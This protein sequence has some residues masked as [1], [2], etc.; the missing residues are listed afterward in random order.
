V[1]R[2]QAC[3][4]VSKPGQPILKHVVYRLVDDAWGKQRSEVEREIPVCRAC[5]HDLDLGVPLADVIQAKAPKVTPVY[6][7]AVNRA[8]A[9]A[10]ATQRRSV[11]TTP[12]PTP[13]R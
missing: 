10:A 9:E 6:L 1:Y 7:P 13:E 4:R 11:L 12:N 3:R 8:E 5:L 2:C